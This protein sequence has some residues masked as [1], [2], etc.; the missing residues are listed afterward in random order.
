M[1]QHEIYMRRCLELAQLGL[2]QTA[3]NPIVGAVLVYQNRIIGEGY[4]QK[5]GQAHAEVNCINS[6]QAQ[7]LS[8]ISHS[9]LYVSL[10]PCSHVGKTPPCVDLI[11]KHNI[12]HVVIACQDSSSKVNGRGIKAL[13][14]ANVKVEMGILNEAGIWLNRRFFTNQKYQR[15]YI[16]LKWAQSQDGF[17]AKSNQ[18]TI[19]SNSISS[20]L[21][22]RWRSEEDAIWV[23]YNTVL[24]D[25][26]SL[27][28]RYWKGKSPIRIVYDKISSLP[29]TSILF[30]QQQ[31]TFVFNTTHS[32]VKENLISIQIEEGN[33]IQQIVNYL[34]QQHISS[35]LVEGGAKL[36]Q[37]LIELN[38]WDEIRIIESDIRLNE[39]TK[40]VQIPSTAIPINTYKIKQDRIQVFKNDSI[41]L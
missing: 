40:A 29:I 1:Q 32:S 37:S 25:N 26:P 7:D 14:D 19:I 10:E 21:V 3:S 34:H 20:K 4:H 30:N 28:N 22:H 23:G 2:G 31:P 15:P 27:D 17:I 13:T 36:H 11:I 24:I 33:K 38:L 18:K 12:S 9:T 8:F 5:Y 16:I 35:V 6:V 41:T 39:G